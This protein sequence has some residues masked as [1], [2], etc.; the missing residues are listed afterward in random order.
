MNDLI[1][2]FLRSE[3]KL[4][5][6][7]EVFQNVVTDTECRYIFRQ[8]E[9]VRNVTKWPELDVVFNAVALMHAGNSGSRCGNGCQNQF[10]W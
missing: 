8:I 3:A 5:N 10:V 7:P 1:I 9:N 2:P 6:C 4:A